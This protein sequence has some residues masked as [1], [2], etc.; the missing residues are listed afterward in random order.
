[1]KA[2][3][4]LLLLLIA[5]G[6]FAYVRFYESKQLT[7][8]EAAERATHVVAIDPDKIDGISITNNEEK[9]ELRKRDSRWEL[10]A[11]V[12]DRADDAAVQ[13]LLT[14]IQTLKKETS[15]DNTGKDDVRDL[16]LVKSN[17]TLQLQGQ[18]APPQ[19]LFGKDTAIEGKEYIRL[20]NS[21]V[22]YVVANDLRNQVTKKAAD[23]RDHRLSDINA[24]QV[25]QANIK[26]AAGEIELRKD[27]DHWEIGKPIKARGDDA[28]IADLLAQMLN[29]KIDSFATGDQATAA[30][31]TALND[32]RGSVTL[33]AEGVDKPLVL[34]I[35]KPQKNSDKLYAKLSTRDAIFML[36]NGVAAILDTKPN[37]VRDKHLIRLNLDT[38]DRI[39]IIPAGAPEI[40]LARKGE[41]WTIKSLNDRAAN[42][43]DVQK[44]ASLLQNQQVAAF[45]SDVATDLP[46]YGLDQPQLKVTFS[47]FASENTAESKAGEEPLDTIL[48]GKADGANVYAKLQD[49]PFIVSV[50]KVILDGIYSD[51]LKW[52][53]L[54]I[55]KFTPDDIVGLDVTKDGQATLSLVKEKGQWKPAKGDIALN[56]GNV[57]SL[58]SALATLRAVQWAGAAKPEHGLEKPAVS[59]TFTTKDKKS[60]TVKI[61]S[62]AGDYWNAGATGWDGVFTL[63]R[64]DHD[65]FVADLLPTAKASAS[66]SAAGAMQPVITPGVPP[67]TPAATSVTTLPVEAK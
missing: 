1:M 61:G 56:T 12:K 37:D 23:F 54:A 6:L 21:N 27:R 22:V 52:Q 10:D 55:Y 39:H 45:V 19:I 46:K 51:S 11:P 17:V 30:A 47:A 9:I 35:S 15:M 7:T 60:N 13:Q 29:T 24:S 16:G 49:E 8:E 18:D 40:L 36:P 2:R 3:H 25:T 41:A 43:G 20:G 5:G 26:T 67:A 48:F 4:T 57:Q 65:A 28:K 14:T 53:D 50:P 33:A 63:S 38:V 64:P 42:S 62:P 58:A 31:N 32:P 66:P 44:A 59:I 34:Q